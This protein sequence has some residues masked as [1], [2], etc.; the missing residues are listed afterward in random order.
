MSV[1]LS[2]WRLGIEGARQTG[3]GSRLDGNL[4]VRDVN[5]LLC[6]SACHTVGSILVSRSQLHHPPVSLFDQS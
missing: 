5:V 2:L 6:D 3:R 4:I 1:T